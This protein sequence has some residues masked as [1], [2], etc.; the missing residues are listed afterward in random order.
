MNSPPIVSLHKVWTAAEVERLAE[1]VV[2]AMRE[3]V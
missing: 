1:C 2:T 3:V